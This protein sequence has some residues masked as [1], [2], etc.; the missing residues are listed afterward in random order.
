[1]T[2]PKEIFEK[3][4]G[5]IAQHFPDFKSIQKGRK[6]KKVSL[7]KSIEFE[8]YFQ[9]SMR[10]YSGNVAILPHINISSKKMEKWL[11]T[12]SNEQEMWELIFTKQLGYLTP[13]QYWH[14]WNLAGLSFQPTIDEIVKCLKEY[15]LPIFELFENKDKAV[16][17]L[18]E[19]GAI[20]NKNVK[21]DE[22][23]PFYFVFWHSGKE[24]A[25]I[26]LNNFVEKCSYKGKFIKS[27]EKLQT[28]KQFNFNYSSFVGEDILKFAVAH[29]IKLNIKE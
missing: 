7:D 21:H 29:G 11:N 28:A 20:F 9:T 26:F 8:I 22:L 19:N 16:D 5:E 25:E 12:Q 1:M 27:Y 6:L 3:G 4:C 14:E 13:R 15:A 10:N 17:F 18:L 23:L 2:S 24:K